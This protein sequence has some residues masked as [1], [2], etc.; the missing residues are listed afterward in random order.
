MFFEVF[1]DNQDGFKIVYK[2]F[3]KRI[4]ALQAVVRKWDPR[5]KAEKTKYSTEFSC[6]RW[7]GLS[8]GRKNGHTFAN[9]K[10]CYQNYAQIHAWFPVKSLKLKSK[11]KENPF[12]V[13]A[14][15]NTNIG[16]IKSMKTQEKK[17]SNNSYKR[18][19]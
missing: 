12:R 17:T 10:G 2:T 15:L 5:K 14:E 19:I 3:N 11:A 16:K 6:E 9:C 4:L 1:V 18:N 8:L 7:F 13:A